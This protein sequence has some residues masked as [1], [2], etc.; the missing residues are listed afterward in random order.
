MRLKCSMCAKTI[1]RIEVLRIGSYYRYFHDGFSIP[2]ICKEVAGAVEQHLWP[3]SI[4]T[5]HFA[6]L[7]G[8]AIGLVFYFGYPKKSSM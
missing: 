8:L 6:H 4:G 5:N 2:F 7:G 3:D 1:D